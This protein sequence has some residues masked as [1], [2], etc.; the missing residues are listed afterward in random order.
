MKSTPNNTKPK[1]GSRKKE[2]V[3]TKNG[4]FSAKLTR[5]QKAWAD[6]YID[7]PKAPLTE[8]ARQTYNVTEASTASEISRQN[9]KKPEIQLYLDK[10][11]DKAR[12]R[13]VELIDTDREDI[14]LRASQDILDRTHGKATQKTEVKQQSVN[15]NLT[16]NN[17]QLTE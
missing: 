10:H 7:N 4:T 14:A 2:Q 1:T 16:F 17:A 5:K 15:V 6:T 9:L 3:R 8:I 12:S 11:I 13:I